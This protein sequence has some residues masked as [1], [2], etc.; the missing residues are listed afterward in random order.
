MIYVSLFSIMALAPF[1]SGALMDD[2]A[3][4]RDKVLAFI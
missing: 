3:A 2:R 1:F 4:E